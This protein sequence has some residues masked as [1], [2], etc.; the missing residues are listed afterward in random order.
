MNMVVL[1]Q[2]KYG[3]T[4]QYATQ[5]A[6]S[7]NCPVY[8]RKGITSEQ[9]INYDYII[10]GGPIYAGGVS[11]LDVIVKNHQ[12]LH[13]KKIVLFTVGLSDTTSVDTINERTNEIKKS[14]P[15]D[16]SVELETFHLRGRLNYKKLK[17][18]HRVVVLLINLLNRKNN[19]M[20]SF[21]KAL[22]FSENRNIDFT[23]EKNLQP[24]IDHIKRTF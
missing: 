17:H 18:T 4:K 7:L 9:I 21:E 22:H 13:S 3:A 19:N 10:Y 11:G 14:I 23:D 1:Y 5:L 8:N 6:K 16:L 15:S 12:K 20:T 24:I 2:S